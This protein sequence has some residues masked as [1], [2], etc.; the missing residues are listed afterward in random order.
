MT[1]RSVYGVIASND[2]TTRVVLGEAGKLG[3]LSQYLTLFPDRAIL[4]AG[5]QQTVRYRVQDA[6][7][8]AHISLVHF[9]MQERGA[10]VDGQIPAIASGLSIVYNLVAP[11]IYF[12]GKWNPSS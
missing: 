8:G 3:D 7:E 9:A 6:P 11:L 5:G 12:R 10:V 2:S 4:P 1:I